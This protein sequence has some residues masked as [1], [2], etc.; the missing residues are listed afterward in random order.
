MASDLCYQTGE[1]V[2]QRTGLFTERDMQGIRVLHAYTHRKLHH[3]FAWR[4]VSYLSFVVSSTW[5]GLRAGPI[6]VVMGTSPPIF[7]FLSAWIVA[8]LRRRPLL[9]EVRDLWPE[10]AV[11]M[12]VLTNPIIIKL[13]RWGERFFYAQATHI[14]VNSPAYRVYLI[15]QGVP[16]DKISL[17]P[18]GVDPDMFD[19]CS[20]GAALRGELGL[21]GQFVVT[22]AGALGQANDISTIR[23]V[24]IVVA[25]DT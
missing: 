13:A 15:D 7:Q 17:I 14:L 19:P 9:L 2:V 25:M 18:N 8:T 6:D 12:G 11:A 23:P 22:Y 10:F 3:S 20:D 5:A 1:P 24:G 21:D 4:V 16:A